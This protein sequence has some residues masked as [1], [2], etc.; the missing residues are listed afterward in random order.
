[1]IQ[2]LLQPTIVDTALS[3]EGSKLGATGRMRA[4]AE[5]LAAGR[6]SLGTEMAIRSRVLV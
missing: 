1:M 2:A 4:P 6:A 3:Q 5:Q